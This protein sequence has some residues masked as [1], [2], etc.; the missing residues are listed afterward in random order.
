[1]FTL[2]LNS[3]FKLLSKT[4]LFLPFLPYQVLALETLRDFTQFGGFN[5]P[6]CSPIGISEKYELK[7]DFV[8]QCP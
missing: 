8:S 7:G 1:M 2:I 4:F 6:M 5:Y 3:L